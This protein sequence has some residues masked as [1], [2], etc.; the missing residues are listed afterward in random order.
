MLTRTIGAMIAPV[1]MVT[2]CLIF[3]N[4][5]FTRY[6]SISFR[7]RA[8]H[9]E[10][11]DMMDAAAGMLDDGGAGSIKSRQLR[12]IEQMERQLPGLLRRHRGVRDAVT[13]VSVALIAL[14]SS[15]F[16]IAGAQIAQLPALDLPALGAFLLGTAAF[17]VSV[18][19]NTRELFR[20]QRE[21]AYEVEDGLRMT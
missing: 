4:G 10:R 14:V 15:M 12:R 9:R 17:L 6:E 1:V 7:M 21:V 18:V 11:L 16:L 13:A 2:S 8:M 5:L 19:I 20:S 3:L